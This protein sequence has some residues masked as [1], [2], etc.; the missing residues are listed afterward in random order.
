[1]IF[2]KCV[3]VFDGGEIADLNFLLT[4]HTVDIDTLISM[5]AL[6]Q[7][8]ALWAVWCLAAAQSSRENLSTPPLRG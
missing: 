7:E 5:V 8:A 1:M 3:D 4:I 2:L 6:S